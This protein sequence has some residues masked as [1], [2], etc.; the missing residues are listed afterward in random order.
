MSLHKRP[1]MH[2]FLAALEDL[3]CMDCKI[4]MPDGEGTE[5]FCGRLPYVEFLG[6]LCSACGER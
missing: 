1:T 5:E 2:D 3:R 6:H 4:E